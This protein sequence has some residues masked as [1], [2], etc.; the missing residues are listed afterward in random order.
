M[1]KVGLVPGLIPADCEL[2][3]SGAEA[4]ATKVPPERGKAAVE[5][6]PQ[7]P[8]ENIAVSKAGA[9]IDEENQAPAP[10]IV[11]IT[12]MRHYDGRLLPQA[13]GSREYWNGPDSPALVCGL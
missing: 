1:E 11:G 10:C 3:K 2:K 6:K 12:V 4:R 8:R 5:R 13:R 9:A 7:K